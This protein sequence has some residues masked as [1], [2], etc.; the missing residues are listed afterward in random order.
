[1]GVYSHVGLYDQTA[2][3]GALPGPPIQIS[4]TTTY[5]LPLPPL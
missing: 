2:A 1:L 5:V 4:P 3:V